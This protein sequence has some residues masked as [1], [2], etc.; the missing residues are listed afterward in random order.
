MADF[1]ALRVV[2]SLDSPK[3]NQD[4]TRTPPRNQIEYDKVILEA[5]GRLSSQLQKAKRMA[6]A[7]LCNVPLPWRHTREAEV[8]AAGLEHPL[9]FHRRG[10][11]GMYE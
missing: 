8:R 9:R 5:Y 6:E 2:S 4:D 1:D 7:D 10:P 11:G 3:W